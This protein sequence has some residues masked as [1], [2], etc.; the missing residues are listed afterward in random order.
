MSP[1]NPKRPSLIE[2]RRA[3]DEVNQ[4]I[5]LHSKAMA[6]W[7][8]NAI[9]SLPFDETFLDEEGYRSCDFGHWYYANHLEILES[10]P[11]FLATQEAHKAIHECLRLISIKLNRGEKVTPKEADT[12]LDKEGEFLSALAT[13]RDELFSLSYSYDYLTG[14]LNRQAF[15]QLLGREYARLRR[16]NA[17]CSL[18]MVDLDHFKGINDRY[19][20]Q[21]GDEV[22]QYVANF[23]TQRLRPYDLICRFGGEEFL[24]CLPDADL[25]AAHNT[26]ER[27]REHLSESIVK[28]EDGVEIKIT[29]SFGIAPL[30]INESWDK[31]IEH[32]DAA[33]YRAKNEG[34]NR[35]VVL[36]GQESD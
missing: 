24:I 11:A 3:L 13:L 32:A 16:S 15:F 22:L 8:R 23:L 14:T 27:V 2:I 6:A 35:T 25:T 33:L 19:G 20:H 17:P 10:H 34:R 31:T 29:A 9:C 36:K 18:V 30:T 12:F 21:A 1:D 5:L 28:L 7:S 26:I 4:A